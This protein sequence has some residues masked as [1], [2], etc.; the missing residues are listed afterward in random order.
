MISKSG[1]SLALLIYTYGTNGLKVPGPLIVNMLDR[2]LI[3]ADLEKAKL[4]EPD[5]IVLFLHWGN[6]YDTVPSKT[7]TD[8][9]DYLLSKGADIIIGSHPHVIQ[10]MIWLKGDSLQDDR[11]TVYSLGNF[12]SN[13]RKP[14][15]DGGAMFRVNLLKTGSNVKVT[16]AGYYLTW[17]YA[18]IINYDK[19]FYI[20]P[21]SEFEKKPDFFPAGTDYTQMMKF[22]KDSR[23]LLYSQNVNVHEYLFKNGSWI[24]NK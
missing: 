10:K 19:K 5:A 8:L 2:T 3:T 16:G 1:F 12:V 22:I 6:E 24:L 9:A 20:L 14:K 18:P 15:T 17:V 7:Q 21:C 4:L 13:Q 23:S 11:V